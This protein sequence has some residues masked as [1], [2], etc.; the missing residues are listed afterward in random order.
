M[1]LCMAEIRAMYYLHA[2]GPFLQSFE[3]PRSNRSF[4]PDGSC[5]IRKL[6]VGQS[7][8]SYPWIEGPKNIDVGIPLIRV[9]LSIALTLT[10]ASEEGI[11]RDGN[12][13]AAGNVDMSAVVLVGG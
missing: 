9:P 1:R 11:F 12:G 13:D 8:T 5:S 2:G 4:F 7:K 10:S 3:I 6:Y